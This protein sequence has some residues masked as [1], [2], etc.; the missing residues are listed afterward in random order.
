MAVAPDDANRVVSDLGDV[1]DVY[2]AL[3]GDF[4]PFRGA[5]AVA[6]AMC[7]GAIAAQVTCRE[8]GDVIVAECHAEDVFVGYVVDFCRVGVPAHWCLVVM[9]FV[10][11]T[12]CLTGLLLA[13]N[14]SSCIGIAVWAAVLSGRRS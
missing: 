7:A 3:A 12:V 14:S 4:F 9:V 5:A 10:W 2:L 8:L 13:Q 6:L 11:E 1:V